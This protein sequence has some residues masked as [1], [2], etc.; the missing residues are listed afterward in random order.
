MLYAQKQDP[1]TAA[2]TVRN[3][4]KRNPVVS[5]RSTIPAAKMTR[6]KD[7]QLS[8]LR[9]ATWDIFEKVSIISSNS[10]FVGNRFHRTPNFIKSVQ[11][12]E[13]R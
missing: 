7:Q 12:F 1:P 11:D 8:L 3:P 13:T 2:R 9:N 5:R 4:S 10:A 6:M